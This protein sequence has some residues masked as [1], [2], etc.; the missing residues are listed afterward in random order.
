MDISEAETGTTRLE[1]TAINLPELVRDVRELYQIL[2]EEKRITLSASVPENLVFNADRTRIQQCLAN[3]VDNALKY[4]G[5]GGKV[6]ITASQTGTETILQV[7]DNGP[8]IAADELP[9]I[10]ERLYRSDKSRHEKGLGLGLSLVKAFT[11]AHKG[12]V[13]VESQPGQGAVFTLRLPR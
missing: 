8:G 6:E 10:W 1:V 13:A 11:E 4:T 2:A 9:R 12:T 3:L 7:R 5:N